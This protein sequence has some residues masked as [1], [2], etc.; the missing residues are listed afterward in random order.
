M[1]R[2]NFT[3][4]IAVLAAVVGLGLAQTLPALAQSGDDEQAAL[5]RDMSISQKP[6]F[7]VLQQIISPPG[8]SKLQ[9]DAWVDNRSQA[10]RIGDKL[11]VMVRPRQDAHIAIVDVGSSGK[12][13]VLYPNHFQKDAVIRANSTLVLPA[14][15]A[16]YN[17]NVGGPVGVSVIHIIASR[18]TLT[19]PEITAAIRATGAAPFATA[20]RTADE[21]ARDLS[22]QAKPQSPTSQPNEMGG[23][24][25]LVRVAAAAGNAVAV[26]PAGAG[27]QIAPTPGTQVASKGGLSIR[28]DKPVYK[29]GERIQ[30]LVTSKNDCRLN[31][32]NFNS[33]GAVIQLFPN[34]SQKNDLIK[35][36]QVLV[37]PSPQMQVKAE[38][39]AGVGGL[40]AVCRSKANE[41][42]AVA[43]AQGGFVTMGSVQTVSRDMLSSQASP[44]GS[45]EDQASGSYII[46]E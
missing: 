16:D 2:F 28:S 35:M 25:I 24:T 10:Y 11:K 5:E 36:G 39:P 46:V 12:V 7:E 29:V 4:P 14:E 40:I 37:I 20:G 8:G 3:T 26:S 21:F 1:L 38:L 13:T 30:I 34:S 45:D 41:A 43:T 32:L 15:K 42:P 18:K 23:K 27:G 33:N 9:V 22:V 31:V 19:M 6:I 17:I 44:D